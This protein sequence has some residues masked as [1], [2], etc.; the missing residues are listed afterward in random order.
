MAHISHVALQYSLP[1]M[2]WPLDP[3]SAVTLICSW[4]A[5][6]FVRK[7]KR[8]EEDGKGRREGGKRG[9]LV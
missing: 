5:G 6:G 8:K 9:L 4:Q 1:L 2:P 3:R 7:M